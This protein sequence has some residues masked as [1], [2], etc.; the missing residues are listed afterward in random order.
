MIR[1]LYY[2]LHDHPLI[3]IVHKCPS[4]S[5]REVTGID[6]FAKAFQGAECHLEFKQTVKQNN[7]YLETKHPKRCRKLDRLMIQNF[8]SEIIIKRIYDID[9]SHRI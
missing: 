6:I 1:A 5:R 9:I 2:H 3:M 4:K 7:K 8:K